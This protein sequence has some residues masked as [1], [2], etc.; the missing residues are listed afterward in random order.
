MADIVILFEHPQRDL[1]N[2]L[3]IKDCLEIKGY[4]CDII[5]YPFVNPAR[6]QIKYR[7]KVKSVITHS[8]YND[9]VIYNLVYWIF[10][11]TDYIFNLQCEQIRTNKEEMDVNSYSWP[12]A[13]ARNAYH[14]CWGE[15][16]V[17][18]LVRSGIKR[19]HLLLAGPI[20]MDVW[21]EEFKGLFMSKKE[22]MDRFSLDSRFRIALFISS[23]S[24]AHLSDIANRQ[25]RLIQ[26]DQEV[27]RF[28][29]ISSVSQKEILKWFKRYLRD[30]K[31]I[32]L[33]YRKHPAEDIND[34][35]FVDLNK[36]KNFK[37]ISE[38]PIN[39]WI[40]NADILLNWYSTSGV[41]AYFANKLSV[42]LRP[43]KIPYEQDM[44]IF[45]NVEVVE[46]Y[47]DFESAMSY[48][49]NCRLD[50]DVIKAYYNIEDIP[51]YIRV[52]SLIDATIKS[53]NKFSWKSEL[54]KVMR[55]KYF[56]QIMMCIPVY[57]YSLIIEIMRKGEEKFGLRF[58]K[59]IRNRINRRKLEYN[60]QIADEKEIEYII[61]N[62]RDTIHNIIFDEVN[63]E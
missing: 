16:V 43:M 18:L 20:Q 10:G 32:T 49:L 21:R 24:Y 52:S 35:I 45:N 34:K 59:S 17:E 46:S 47:D 42:I 2:V 44:G 11:K 53:G 40:N 63:A 37:I 38:L 51:S 22:I 62:K 29:D 56:Q 30:H 60:R 12:K 28:A 9:N 31:D 54:L 3:M 25:L 23:F 48:G 6:L 4:S 39:E 61:K 19:E 5:K 15:K 7:N 33:V 26:G 36:F 57:L 8:L 41:E 58:P 27:T 50:S 55:K 14:I 13:H 1:E